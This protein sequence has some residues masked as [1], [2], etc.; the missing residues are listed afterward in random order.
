MTAVPH[1]DVVPGPAPDMDH[2]I[3]E[4]HGRAEDLQSELF[5]TGRRPVAEGYTSAEQ[6]SAA[7]EG[8]RTSIQVHGGGAG[9]VA[10][11]TA[12][13]HTTTA[14]VGRIAAD[15]GE[16]LLGLTP[17]TAELELWALTGQSLLGEAAAGA[18]F[19]A[20]DLVGRIAHMGVTVARLALAAQRYEATEHAVLGM[21]SAAQLNSP[22]HGSAATLVQEVARTAEAL[23]VALTRADITSPADFASKVRFSNLGVVVTGGGPGGTDAVI[24][25]PGL[26]DVLDTVL[27]APLSAPEDAPGAG[28]GGPAPG[29]AASS[30]NGGV[31]EGP[32]T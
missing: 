2:G 29:G 31:G 16:V 6:V 18:E 32:Q 24:R 19:L 11:D 7:V 25:G 30:S 15:L 14:D 13:L 22:W 3:T 23:D 5:G 10:V 26:D 9:A 4:V 21:F 8:A 12:D 17:L 1:R 27:Q 28:G 20:G